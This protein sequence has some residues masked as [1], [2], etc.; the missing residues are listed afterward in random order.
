[1]AWTTPRTWTTGELV[2]KSIMDTHVRDNLAYLKNSPTFDGLITVSGFGTHTFSSSGAGTNR[3]QIANT[4]SGVAN[5]AS[6]Q[7]TAGTSNTFLFSYSQGYTSSGFEVADGGAVVNTSSG[8]LSVAA[9]AASTTVR[10]YAAN[11]LAG[12]FTSTGMTIPGTLAVTGN[13]A[14]NTNKFTVTAASG[15]TL[16]AGTL[17]VT[18]AA[19]LVS[20]LAFSTTASVLAGGLCYNST[21]GLTMK[22]KTGSSYDFSIR[23]AAG[24]LMLS[25]ATGTTDLATA[26]ALTVGA[27]LTVTTSLTVSNGSITAKGPLTL[28]GTSSGQP[29][30]QISSGAFG[31]GLVTGAILGAG[32]N[33]SGSTAAGAVAMTAKGGT[34]Y[35]TWPDNTGVLRIHTSAP[36]ENGTVSDTAGTVVGTQTSTRASKIIDGRF[37]DTKKALRTLLRTPLYRFRYKSGAYNRQRFVGITTDDSPA[38]GMDKGRSF[39]PVSAFGFTVAA[40]QELAARL[41]ALEAR[42]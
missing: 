17:D 35:Y 2:T 34:N 16:V 27:A 20:T 39:N 8:G 12:T 28:N 15:N 14:V 42:A 10:V 41:A 22:G 5:T 13:V 30:M 19:T 36:T 4:S 3:I 9:T 11:T 38:F 31:T 29:V 7:T 1:M 33:T 21:D 25:N 32:R 24:N 40:I 37:T 18:G 23:D 26:A 6:L